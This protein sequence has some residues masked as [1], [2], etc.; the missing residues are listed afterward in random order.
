MSPALLF[1][2]CA[3]AAYRATRLIV[4]DTILDRP[5]ERLFDRFPPDGDR[6]KLR[7]DWA[8]W[9]SR[10]AGGAFMLPRT[11][12]VERFPPDGY[13]PVSKVG[14][15]LECQFCAGV[16]LS[17]LTV[18]AVWCVLSLPLPALWFVG[19]MGAQAL[20]SATDARLSG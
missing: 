17:A 13:R 1:A 2:L 14:Q 10:P 4:S 18:G 7:V 15:L 12:D 9:G 19:V 11:P 3:L 20:L 6:A 16:W 8:R 5:R